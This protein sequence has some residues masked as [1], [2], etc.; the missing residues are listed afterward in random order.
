MAAWAA[1]GA[2]QLVVGF[3]VSWPAI[4]ASW[5][6]HVSRWHRMSDAYVHRAAC[7]LTQ[8]PILVGRRKRNVYEFDII[9]R[10]TTLKPRYDTIYDKSSSSIVRYEYRLTYKL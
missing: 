1:R 2:T 9:T 10:D 8:P 4:E 3:L 7:P 5:C 6:V